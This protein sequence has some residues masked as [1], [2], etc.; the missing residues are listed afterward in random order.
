MMKKTRSQAEIYYR[1]ARRDAQQAVQTDLQEY[2]G[3]DI[4]LTDFNEVA[5]EATDRWRQQYPSARGDHIPGWNWRRE[6]RR[7]RNRPRRVEVV[8]WHG[9]IVCGVALG[10]ISD[11]CVVATIHLV[12]SNPE[13]NP[14][15][16][17]VVPFIT[18]FLETLAVSLGC[19]EVS[20]EQPAEG[21][22]DYYAEIGFA[23]KVMKGQRVVR[24]KMNLNSRLG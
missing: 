2:S 15:A 24:Q 20:I 14:L 10:R 18:R 23:K 3:G 11:R 13:G 22:V 19:K 21:L 8:L 4:R 1:T 6:L 17:S 7:F 9:D 16:G 12:E 5:L